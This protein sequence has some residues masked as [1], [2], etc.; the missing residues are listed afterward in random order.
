MAGEPSLLARSFDREAGR[1]AG[2]MEQALVVVGD[3]PRPHPGSKAVVLVGHGFGRM[4]GG[5]LATARVSYDPEYQEA[6]RLLSRARATVYC[7]DVTR[8]DSH[9]LETGLMRVAED[10]GGFFMRTNW[11]P[12]QAVSRLGEALAGHYELSV[13]KPDLPRGEHVIRVEL[14]GRKGVVFARRTYV[15]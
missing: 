12:A 4:I 1:R 7:L 10:T 9:T 13:E 5:G 15:G 2:S 14:V 8:A 6:R 3:A 11:F